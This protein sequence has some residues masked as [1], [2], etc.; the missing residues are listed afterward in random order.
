[1]GKD[2]M[3]EDSVISI[4]GEELSKSLD[5]IM[6][7]SKN[8]RDDLPEWIS[9]L[10]ESKYKVKDIENSEIYIAD[11]SN[12]GIADAV[13]LYV[14]DITGKNKK[15]EKKIIYLAIGCKSIPVGGITL[16]SVH[17]D[18]IDIWQSKFTQLYSS[19]EGT[20]F[21]IPKTNKYSGI[22]SL[23]AFDIKKFSDDEIKELKR[24][25]FDI[26]KFYYVGT[27]IKAE[28]SYQL[29]QHEIVDYSKPLFDSKYESKSSEIK[30]SDESKN[31]NDDLK[32]DGH[33]S[34]SV[35]DIVPLVSVAFMGLLSMSLVWARNAN[36][37]IHHNNQRD[38][39]VDPVKVGIMT[40]L[41]N[42]FFGGQA[43]PAPAPAP[44]PP[45][46]EEERTQP[47]HY[48]KL[49]PSSQNK[50]QVP[51]DNFEFGEDNT[52]EEINSPSSRTIPHHGWGQSS[53]S[54]RGGAVGWRPSSSSS[55]TAAFY[56]NQNN[57]LTPRL[58]SSSS[59]TAAFHPPTE[60]ALRDAQIAEHPRS[61]F[62]RSERY[63]DE[64]ESGVSELSHSQRTVI[65]A[66]HRKHPR[67][68]CRD[69]ESC[70]SKRIRVEKIDQ[71]VERD[72]GFVDAHISIGADTSRGG[73]FFNS[74]Y[75]L[76]A[77]EG[78]DKI[79]IAKKK[80]LP[81]MKRLINY[82]FAKQED[83]FLTE[84]TRASI[85]ETIDGIRK[86]DG[87]L[88]F[89]AANKATGRRVRNAEH[90]FESVLE[91]LLQL[92]SISKT[93]LEAL[94]KSLH[95]SQ[96]NAGKLL[97][98]IRDLT[99]DNSVLTEEQKVELYFEYILY[100][101]KEGFAKH[102]KESLKALYR[103]ASKE[104]LRPQILAF[105]GAEFLLSLG[106][107]SKIPGTRAFDMDS[108]EEMMFANSTIEMEYEEYESINNA[109]DSDYELP[110]SGIDDTDFANLDYQDLKVEEK[111]GDT[112]LSKAESLA[113]FIA[114]VA[115][116]SPSSA[117]MAICANEE[118]MKN[119]PVV[120]NVAEVLFKANVCHLLSPT[121]VLRVV[122]S[123]GFDLL[124]GKGVDANDVALNAFYALAGQLLIGA[125]YEYLL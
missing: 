66:L 123:S 19:D 58:S 32:D 86:H 20:V 68:E 25:F 48:R 29:V 28:A 6:E 100:R 88:N 77:G 14:K 35:N 55:T 118:Y 84:A 12:K 8:L 74:N 56:S 121:P 27:E 4:T 64:V 16:G 71:V 93:K 63:E 15:V 75:A 10:K 76:A 40:S 109:T 42:L 57:G 122:C 83:N 33:K 30:S 115:V 1:M 53:I 37:P 59:A 92:T 51:T 116:S 5:N 107:I 110:E 124:E 23:S 46:V 26:M 80:L 62:S 18:A 70:T 78:N 43:A 11:Y 72:L 21:L 13:Y 60:M 67:S 39:V 45:P 95:I 65:S 103:S 112:W 73:F 17:Q 91:K 79:S 49:V 96:E 69:D 50:Q 117:S 101:M 7:E 85:I 24:V 113:K 120:T 22:E 94:S 47:S 119:L 9:K 99:E 81:D 36:N 3:S 108:Y 125:A 104:I 87:T 98:S 106:V 52:Q 82:I 102:Y 114:C 97:K 111:T 105:F 2:E 34:M 41:W 61:V 38:V 89:R 31:R 54:S 44:A 90:D